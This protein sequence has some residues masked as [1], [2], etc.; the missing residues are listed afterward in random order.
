MTTHTLAPHDTPARIIEAA[1]TILRRGG[2]ASATT[3]KVAEAAGVPLSQIHYHFG[4]RRGLM[5]GVL[6]HQNAQLVRRQ[7]S[8]FNADASL[9][10]QWQRA[11]DAYDEDLASGYVR[12]LQE[13]IAAGWSDPEIAA[14]VSAMLDAWTGLLEG[15]AER[16]AAF[17]NYGPLSPQDV[18][19]LIG[20]AWLGAEALHMLR[21]E[22]GHFDLRSSLRNVGHMI[23]DAEER[24]TP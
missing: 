21:P 9:W 6:R 1:E 23:R 3:R 2:F 19:R 5:L 20:A 17:L 14:E 24:R 12:L 11:C 22:D 18:G 8:L 7:E 4:S 15:L 13:M 10:M 16:A